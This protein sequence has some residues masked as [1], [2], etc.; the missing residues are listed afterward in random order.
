MSTKK[1]VN[2]I[3][4]SYG[5]LNGLSSFFVGPQEV[6]PEWYSP[7]L[8]NEEN[9]E[10]AQ[11]L[12]F[13]QDGHVR[14]FE[15]HTNNPGPCEWCHTDVWWWDTGQHCMVCDQPKYNDL[16]KVRALVADAQEDDHVR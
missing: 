13:D 7:H 8:T 10:L 12:D 6:N 4:P 1:E 16:L 9:A 3:D 11:I 2:D 14:P 5:C 15:G